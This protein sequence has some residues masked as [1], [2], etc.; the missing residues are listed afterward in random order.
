[1]QRAQVQC[2]IQEGHKEQWNGKKIEEGDRDTA[3]AAWADWLLKKNCYHD[4]LSGRYEPELSDTGLTRYSTCLVSRLYYFN[5]V[6]RH[7][8]RDVAQKLNLSRLKTWPSKYNRLNSTKPPAS[9]A[10]NIGQFWL[11][12]Q[13]GESARSRVRV[14]RCVSGITAVVVPEFVFLRSNCNQ[15]IGAGVQFGMWDPCWRLSRKMTGALW[16]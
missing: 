4:L 10:G 12:L 15:V 9:G 6:L 1:M 3:P 7:W 16:M 14:Y 8:P 2:T 13:G 5:T 11:M